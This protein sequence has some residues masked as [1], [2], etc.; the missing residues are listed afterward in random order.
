MSGFWDFDYTLTI[1]FE[2]LSVV[3]LQAILPFLHKSSSECFIDIEHLADEVIYRIDGLKYDL[4]AKHNR[5][6][7]Q[8]IVATF[9]TL[10]Q[11]APFMPEPSNKIRIIHDMFNEYMYCNPNSPVASPVV[12]PKIGSVEAEQVKFSK[13][14]KKVKKGGYEKVPITPQ[15]EGETPDGGSGGIKFPKIMSK[16]KSG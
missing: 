6:L 2:R 12:S 10:K 9:N 4:R 3:D 1:E 14:M 8:L 13:I 11:I 7:Q 15:D 16:F 5:R